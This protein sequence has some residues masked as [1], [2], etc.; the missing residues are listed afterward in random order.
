MDVVSLYTNIPHEEGLRYVESYLDTIPSPILPSKAIIPL[1]ELVLKYNNFSFGDEHFVQIHG[2]AMGSRVSPNYANLFM[3]KF[4][5][6]MLTSFEVKPFVF[7]RYIDDIFIIW[8]STLASLN[9]FFNHCNSLH[10]TIKFSCSYSSTSVSFLDVT[11][12]I[13]SGKLA[14]TLLRKPTDRRQYLHFNSYH[15]HCQKKSIPYGQ[16]L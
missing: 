7:Y 2:A 14:T 3:G 5:E 16:F 6:K 1:L 12:S 9:A 4:E 8:T 11:V 10:N 15:P 13:D